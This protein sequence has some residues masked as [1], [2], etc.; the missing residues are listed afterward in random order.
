YRFGSW[1]LQPVTI[2]EFRTAN[3]RS[4]APER[5]RQANLRV[6]SLNLGNLFNGDG[7][8]DGFPTR[9]GAQRTGD[10]ERQL[11]RLGAQIRATDAD[12]LAVSELEN[13]G[14][15]RHSALAQLA[16]ELGGRWR[17]VKAGTDAHDD[18]IRNALLYRSDRVR[19][20]GQA[21]LI[22]GGSF[23]RWHRPAVAQG[24]ELAAGS[25]TVTVV[26]VHLKSKSCRKA[27]P[28]QQD[29]GD[30]QA[31][32]ARARTE[33]AGDLARWRPPG[34]DRGLVLL[35][36]DFNAY[37][38]EDPLSLL[39]E[40]GFRDL[41]RH[42]HG[43]DTQTFRYHGRHGTL[44]YQLASEALARRVLDSRIWSVN[45]EEPRIWSYN[46]G[47]GMA[48]PPDYPWRASDHNP[49]ITDLRLA[50]P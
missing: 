14:Y 23:R 22:D 34:K 11:D 9:R 25:E 28:S 29:R 20:R 24:F 12:I 10:Y 46:A 4:P 27:P 5:H 45:A 43:T 47:Q 3:R 8:G 6:V 40:Q 21:S 31:C 37:A 42:F 44:D 15:H 39:A 2:P 35:A 38:R 13:D 48:V 50:D 49:V 41:V 16:E 26:A 18:D 1:R 7:R 17:F 19:P 33:A 30:G 32:F 36:G